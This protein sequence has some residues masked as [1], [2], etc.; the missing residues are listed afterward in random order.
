MHLTSRN[1][2]TQPQRP[3]KVEVCPRCGSTN[4][5]LSSKF[6]AWLMPKQYVC[7]DCG[8]NGPII[9]ELEEDQSKTKKSDDTNQ[10][11]H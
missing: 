3:K 8:Y 9:L 11:C 4:I 2:K 1:I 6:D 5:K 10:N 7:Y